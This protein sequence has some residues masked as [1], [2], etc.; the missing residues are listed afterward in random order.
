MNIDT[1]HVNPMQYINPE[2]NK[3]KI[4]NLL[5]SCDNT[6]FDLGYILSKNVKKINIDDIQIY[7]DHEL[8]KKNYINIKNITSYIREQ[9]Q[10]YENKLKNTY[11]TN[12]AEDFYKSLLK[13]EYKYLFRGVYLSWDNYKINFNLYDLNI[14]T[15][16]YKVNSKNTLSPKFNE[17]HFEINDK[18]TT[19]ED[20]IIEKNELQKFL[21]SIH[22]IDFFLEYYNE[23]KV[24]LNE[25]NNKIIFLYTLE[26]LINNFY[27]DYPGYH[28]TV[29]KRYFY[30]KL[31]SNSFPI[32]FGNTDRFTGSSYISIN[33]VDKKYKTCNVDVKKWKGSVWNGFMWKRNFKKRNLSLLYNQIRHLIDYEK[34]I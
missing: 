25:L 30:D 24:E 33:S 10:V 16:R 14:M 31:K 12:E 6:N 4:I 2:N 19:I 18:F 7:F 20:Y 11:V 13:D 23:K 28:N 5:F 29:K 21:L 34:N 8:N 15:I 1:E 3:Y 27:D 9:I 22:N 26:K 32:I 17:Y